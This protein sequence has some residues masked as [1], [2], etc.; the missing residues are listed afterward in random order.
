MDVFTLAGKVIEALDAE[1]VPYLVVGALSVSVF[2]IPRATKDVDIV[3]SL[4]TRQP[5]TAV[6]QR[7]RDIAEF[8]PQISFETITGS[9]RHLLHSRTNPPIVVEHFELGGDP[10]VQ[11]RFARRRQEFSAQMQRR[12]WLPTPEDVIVQKLRWARHKDLDDAGSVLAVR[13]TANLDLPYIEH[14]CAQHGSLPRLRE[15]LASIP[16]DLR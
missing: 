9:V 2:G 12:A 14:W 5:L 13:G 3:I 16:P 6:A 1:H 11:S 15:V 8:D 10:F 7:L 4:P